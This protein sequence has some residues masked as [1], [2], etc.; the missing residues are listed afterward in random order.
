MNVN[1]PAKPS[2][3][4]A[5]FVVV[6]P[7]RSPLTGQTYITVLSSARRDCWDR[8]YPPGA[9]VPS[10]LDRMYSALFSPKPSGS[11]ALVV[12][13]EEEEDDNYKDVEEKEE[14]DDDHAGKKENEEFELDDSMCCICFQPMGTCGE[15]DG[16]K[17]RYCLDCLLQ[18]SQKRNWCPTCRQEFVFVY[19]STWHLDATPA[20]YKRRVVR[21]VFRVKDVRAATARIL[22]EALYSDTHVRCDNH[23]VVVLYQ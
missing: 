20:P 6:R 5:R 19:E 3:A 17:H 10:L 11:P 12:R 16:C 21:S 2:P 1:K 9:L 4:A 8:C 13:Q 18:W 23:S 14:D 15:M 22:P 7:V